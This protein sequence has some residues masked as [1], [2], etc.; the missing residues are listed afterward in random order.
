MLLRTTR[1]S[2]SQQ[3]LSL[4]GHIPR[5]AVA[6]TVIQ[7]LQRMPISLIS[8]PQTQLVQIQLPMPLHHLFALAQKY[9]KR[10]PEGECMSLPQRCPQPIARTPL[11][12]TRNDA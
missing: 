9:T 6:C 1:P 12:D 4:L 11:Q 5:T 7:V 3:L 10:G 8:L 2:A